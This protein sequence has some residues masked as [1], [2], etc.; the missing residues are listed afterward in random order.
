V[1]SSPIL[2][3]GKGVSRSNAKKKKKGDGDT[4][5]PF[6]KKRCKTISNDTHSARREKKEKKG[7]IIIGISLYNLR[8]IRE[9]GKGGAELIWVYSKEKRKRGKDRQ[10]KSNAYYSII[11]TI[12]NAACDD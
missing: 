9:G 8:Y 12:Y 11:P 6:P 5:F 2:V 7:E 1:Q 4:S 3:K 10:V